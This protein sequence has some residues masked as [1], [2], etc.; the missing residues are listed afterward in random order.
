MR[1][2]IVK[3][4]SC[5]KLTYKNIYFDA[6]KRAYAKENLVI[7]SNEVKVQII[8][9]SE[10]GTKEI[11][12]QR[13][14]AGE[15]CRIMQVYE[16]TECKFLIGVT[17]TNYDEDI[18][19]ERVITGRKNK[20]GSDDY[21]ANTY[22]IQGINKIFR[23]YFDM[24]SQF[25][26]LKLYF[27]LLDTDRSYPSNQYNLCS[28]RMLATLGFD[29]LNIDKIDF[30]DFKNFGFKPNSTFSNLQ[31]PSFNKLMNDKLAISKNNKSNIPAYLKCVEEVLDDGTIVTEKYIYTFK[32]LGAQAYDCFLTMW[33]LYTLAQKEKKNLEFLF[34]LEHYG[35]R[36]PK[37]EVKITKDLPKPVKRLLKIVGIDVHYETSEEILQE[38]NNKASQFER[39]KAANEL[40]N[41]S[42]FRNNLREKG[43]PTKCAICGSEI[44]DLLEAAHL[45]GVAQIRQED[46]R[47]INK[48]LSTTALKDLIDPEDPHRNDMFYKKYTLVNSGDNGIWLCKNHHG[49]FDNNYFCFDSKYGKIIFK[50]ATEQQIKEILGIDDLEEATLHEDILNDRTAVFLEK[51]LDEFH[52]SSGM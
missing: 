20:Y 51:R 8:D 42:L 4:Y 37:R 12:Q 19:A 30:S 47:T 1:N 27:Y 5:N 14:P 22:L 52:S 28:Y 31:Y 32:S 34:S 43:I 21:H 6:V 17:N 33:T 15:H 49:L 44:E 7:S 9:L 41:Q 46:G 18:R 24:K 2:I 40:R 3:I 25:N 23:R 50:F 48:L 45:W 39:A 29:V 10:N 16:G 36:I 38:I 13:A 11:Q 26:N 35:F